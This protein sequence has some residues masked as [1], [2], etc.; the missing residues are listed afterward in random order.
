MVSSTGRQLVDAIKFSMI[1]SKVRSSNAEKYPGLRPLTSSSC[2]NAVLS[3]L[4]KRSQ[5]LNWRLIRGSL[6]RLKPDTHWNGPVPD[7]LPRCKW[8]LPPRGSC[9]QDQSAA[10]L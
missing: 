6:P 9:Q 2:E 7:T 3:V 10:Y 5:S 1:P 4:T 8:H